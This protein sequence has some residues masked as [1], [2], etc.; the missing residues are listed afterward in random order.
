MQ[1][2]ENIAGIFNNQAT[3]SISSNTRVD[4]FDEI[5]LLFEVELRYKALL[6][7]SLEFSCIIA[8]NTNYIFM[9]TELFV[10]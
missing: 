6:H 3:L 1:W 8:K 5:A 2:R 7:S 10:K 4:S 9:N